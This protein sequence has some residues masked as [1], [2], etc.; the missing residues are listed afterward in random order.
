MT[1]SLGLAGAMFLLWILRGALLLI[2]GAVLLSLLLR[3]LTSVI[4]RVP[5]LPRGAGLFLATLFLVALIGG[6]IWLFGS[7]LTLQFHDVAER[8][9]SAWHDL[10]HLLARNGINPS[11]MSTSTSLFAGAVP[12]LLTFGMN[13]IEAAVVLVVMAIYLAAEPQLYRRGVAKLISSK[14]RAKGMEALDMIAT[15][16]KFWMLAQ[17][18]LM[19]I[20]GILSYFALLVIGLPNA[21]VLGLIAGLSEAV[22]YLGPFIGGA[23]AVLVALTQGLV[24]AL[25]TALLYLALHLIE[26]Y[27]IGPMLQRWYVRVP[28]ALILGGIFVSQLLFGFGGVVLGAPFTVALVAAVRVLYIQDALDETVSLPDEP[29]F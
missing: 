26:G 21:A 3:L 24:P 15:S 16:L 17:L 5:R 6:C 8:V 27:L 7:N 25:S 12:S 1:I 19:A 9:K 29:P 14:W 20:V 22:P 10:A 13:F 18:S 4:C 23:P 2:F 11:L 28:P